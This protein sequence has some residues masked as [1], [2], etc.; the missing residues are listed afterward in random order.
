MNNREMIWDASWTFN[1][2]PKEDDTGTGKHIPQEC[3][4]KFRN[5]DILIAPS[6]NVGDGER[7]GF[8]S[9][10]VGIRND[11]NKIRHCPRI[12]Y[13]EAANQGLIQA[14]LRQQLFITF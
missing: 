9:C 14:D 1:V 11:D 7:R 5:N 13:C 3:D 2:P 12:S 4:G 6:T 10:L 8:E